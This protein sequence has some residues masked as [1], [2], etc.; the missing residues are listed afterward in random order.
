[1][2]ATRRSA[3]NFAILLRMSHTSELMLVKQRLYTSKKAYISHSIVDNLPKIY[4]K[5]VMNNINIKKFDN[6]TIAIFL[7]QY[8]KH[9]SE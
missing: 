8:I 9:K 7:L 2:S 3:A 1:M 4:Q 6:A 5:G